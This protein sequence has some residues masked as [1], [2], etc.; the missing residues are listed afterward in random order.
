MPTIRV[1]GTDLTYREADVVSFEGGLIGLPHLR[2]MVLAAQA[3][4][5]PFLWLISLDDPDATFLVVSPSALFDSYAP[6]LPAEELAGQRLD[7]EEPLTVLAIC[8]IAP[9]WTRSTVNLR[10][11]LVISGRE[12]RGAQVVL[13]DAALHVDEPLPLPRAA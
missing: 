6:A 13:A 3:D 12:M 7:A 1:Q 11:P 2:R 10:A 9:D 8:L 4:I 5:N